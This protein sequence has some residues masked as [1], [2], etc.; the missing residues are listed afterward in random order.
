MISAIYALL[1]LLVPSI[2][3]MGWSQAWASAACQALLMTASKINISAATRY[4]PLFHITN[5]HSAPL[6]QGSAEAKEERYSQ[7][8]LIKL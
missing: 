2:A 7:S 3:C 8:K 5:M 4:Q 6:T 1:S